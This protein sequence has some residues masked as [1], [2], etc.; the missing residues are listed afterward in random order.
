MRMTPLM[1]ALLLTLL[2][3]PALAATEDLTGKWS[4]SFSITTDGQAHDESAYMVFTQK[5]EDLTGTAGPTADQQWPIVKGKVK[6]DKVTFDVQS[7]NA[8]IHIELTFKDGHL[9]GEAHAE[10]DGRALSA[11]IDLE[12]VKAP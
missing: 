6:G 9:K 8:L 12:R 10:Q 4:G 7:D 3:V 1:R 11:V 5:G 2:F